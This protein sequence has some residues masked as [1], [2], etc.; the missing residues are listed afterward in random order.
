MLPLLRS[1]ARLAPTQNP[2][3]P[4]QTPSVIHASVD[5]DAAF[6]GVLKERIELGVVQVLDLA[7]ALLVLGRPS[8]RVRDVAAVKAVFVMSGAKV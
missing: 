6:L 4:H 3:L 2:S 5:L 7:I 8:D 1:I